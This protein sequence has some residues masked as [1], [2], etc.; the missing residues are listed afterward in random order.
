MFCW[1]F[2][3]GGATGS[4]IIRET[5]LSPCV[6]GPSIQSNPYCICQ[7]PNVM[8]CEASVKVFFRR[9]VYSNSSTGLEKSVQ[10]V[11]NTPPS[12][13]FGV[14]LPLLMVSWEKLRNDTQCY[15]SNICQ[16]DHGT[17]LPKPWHLHIVSLD[18]TQTRIHKTRRRIQLWL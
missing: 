5:G 15:S 10:V 17:S 11:R 3:P 14:L 8:S 18:S 16:G 9:Q 2:R 7:F 6:W 13:T 4:H 12:P 1:N